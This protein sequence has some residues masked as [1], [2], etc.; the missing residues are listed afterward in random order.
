MPVL[1]ASWVCKGRL[2]QTR[3]VP[4]CVNDFTVEPFLIFKSW[5]LWLSFNKIWRVSFP[6]ARVVIPEMLDAG[7]MLFA[8]QVVLRVFVF[9]S[10]LSGPLVVKLSALFDKSLL[11]VVKVT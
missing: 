1:G 8:S 11:W 7:E 4:S 6:V 2:S 3:F 5:N 9:V 10:K